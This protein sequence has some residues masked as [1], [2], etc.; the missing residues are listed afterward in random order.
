LSNSEIVVPLHRN[1]EVIGVLDVDSIKQA[2]FDETD[3]HYL[4][5]VVRLLLLA[6]PAV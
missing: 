5:E 4:E 2:D 1:G 6:T 3:R